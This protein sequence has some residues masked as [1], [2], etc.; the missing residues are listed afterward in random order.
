MQYLSNNNILNPKPQPQLV[1][2]TTKSGDHMQKIGLLNHPGDAASACASGLVVKSNV[3]IVGPRV[4]FP[5]GAF[6]GGLAQL[7]ERMLSMHEVVG[8]IPTSSSSL[9]FVYLRRKEEMHAS[10]VYHVRIESGKDL[11]LSTPVAPSVRVLPSTT[12]HTLTIICTCISKV[13]SN[14]HILYF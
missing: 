4:R 13:I 11:G 8:S 2:P 10:L 5:A 6:Y 3:A 1:T 12:L 9:Y 7:V 14:V